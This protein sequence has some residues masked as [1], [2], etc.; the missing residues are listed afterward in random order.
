MQPTI[1]PTKIRTVSYFD[2]I[3][4]YTSDELELN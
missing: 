2:I 1:H 4:I 3:I